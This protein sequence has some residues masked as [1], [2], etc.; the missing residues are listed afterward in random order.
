MD[1]VVCVRLSHVAKSL[2]QKVRNVCGMNKKGYIVLDL[3]QIGDETRQNS[4][5]I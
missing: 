2:F 4:M 5:Q 3:G 1:I